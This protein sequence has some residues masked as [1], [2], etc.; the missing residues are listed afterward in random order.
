MFITLSFVVTTALL[1]AQ[2][3]EVT[4]N[5][6]TT[7]TPM[8]TPRVGAAV[9]VIKGS[10]Y[11]VTGATTSAIVTNNEIYNVAKKTWTTGAAIP[12]ARYVP[13]SAV[14]ENILYM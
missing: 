4:H 7:G 5:T 1:Q 13:A 9:G 2:V 8:I 14:V 12:T 11:V 6:W 10:I 3:S